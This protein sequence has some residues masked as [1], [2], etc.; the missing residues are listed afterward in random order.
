MNGSGC[1]A[2][3]HHRSD[4]KELGHFSRALKAFSICSK[5]RQQPRGQARASP[6]QTPKNQRVGM[7]MRPIEIEEE[8]QDKNAEKMP[9]ERIFTGFGFSAS[10]QKSKA[11]FFLDISA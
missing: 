11:P 9:S 6:R 10:N 1:A 3:P 2:L 7:L 5:R 4:A 8:S